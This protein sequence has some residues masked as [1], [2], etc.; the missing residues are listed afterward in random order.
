MKIRRNLLILTLIFTWPIFMM[1]QDFSYQGINYSVLS[2]T[3]LTCQTKPGSSTTSGTTTTTIAGN[4]D[5]AGAVIIPEKVVDASGKEY[6]VTKIGYQSFTKNKN[7]TSVSLPNTILS[8]GESAFEYCSA[9]IG[10]IKLPKSLTEIGPSAFAE[11]TGITGTIHIPAGVTSVP[12]SAFKRCSGITEVILSKSVSSVG[13]FAF[14][15]DSKLS[16]IISLAVTPPTITAQTFYSIASGTKVYVP[17]AGSAGYKSATGWKSLSINNMIDCESVTLSSTSLS[18]NDKE[19]KTLIATITPENVTLPLIEWISSDNTV[20]TVDDEGA[21]TAVGNGEAMITATCGSASAECKVTVGP[22]TTTTVNGINYEIIEGTNTAQVIGCTP[23]TTDIAIESTV[24]IGGQEY[25]VV[26]IKVAAFYSN[27]TITSVSKIPETIAE[28]PSGCFN[29]CSN[30]QEITIPANITSI[31]NRAFA[32]CHKITNIVIPKTVTNIGSGAFQNM[33]GV[34][35]LDVQCNATVDKD[36][37]DG[38]TSLVTL[39][40]NSATL[41][42]RWTACKWTL[43]SVEFGPDVT[44]ISSSAFKGFTKLKSVKFNGSKAV[45][46]NEAFSTC[47]ALTDL[48]LGNSITKI[49]GSA[50]SGCTELNKIIFPESMNFIA[51][52]A[53]MSTGITSIDIPNSITQIETAAFASCPS[54]ITAVIGDGLKSIPMGMF[55]GC[56]KLESVEIG[57]SVATIQSHAFNKCTSLNTLNIPNSVTT[58]QQQAFS[59]CDKLESVTIGNGVMEISDGAFASCTELTYLT[60]GDCQPTIG[61]AWPNSTNLQTIV[62]SSS[63]P[64]VTDAK[65]FPDDVYANAKLYVPENSEQNFKDNE[66]WG[67]FFTNDR[68]NL[69]NGEINHHSIKISPDETVLLEA[70]FT[71]LPENAGNNVTWTSSNPEIATVTQG[72]MVTGIAVGKTVITATSSVNFP[73]RCELTVIAEPETVTLNTTELTIHLGAND[74]LTAAVSPEDADDKTISWSSADEEVAVVDEDGMVTA[75]AVGE[76]IVTATASNGVKAECKVTVIPVVATGLEMSVSEMDLFIGES[77][78]LNAIIEPENTTDKT[79]SWASSNDDIATVENGLVTGVAEGEATITATSHNGLTAT[80][81]VTVKP[82][83]AE[84]VTLDH[85]TFDLTEGDTETLTATVLPE[86][87]TDPT[88]TWSSSDDDIATVE[89]GLVT[90]V[91]EGEATITAACGDVKAECVV[92]VTK[93]VIPAEGITLSSESEELTV[94]DSV[95]LTATITP[96]DVTDPTVIWSS[97]DYDI[98]T[99]ETGLVTAV[100]EGEATIIAACGDVKAECV[101]TVS[102]YTTGLTFVYGENNAVTVTNGEIMT[103]G[104]A[105]IYT[106]E[107]KLAARTDGGRIKG[108]ARGIYIV[109]TRG[110]SIKIS[111]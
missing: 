72:G 103:D 39:K 62:Y 6:R 87:T 76:T 34:T 63:A 78:E 8:I 3:D 90:A 9:I 66:V 71:G 84:E 5:A 13:N 51:T 38:L 35:S 82:I 44:M 50:F 46:D 67:Q 29:Q 69:M 109:V 56:S 53:F 40:Y 88:V 1:A 15:Q 81:T 47:E 23:E 41:P 98:A 102:A 17:E 70:T 12:A 24:S 83:V 16:K 92:T 75:V 80:C 95:E 33:N 32:F 43:E 68:S 26:S 104:A 57:S 37:F 21:V 110:K 54:L 101:V 42:A 25:S 111:L 77:Y 28:I 59:G 100:A 48:D 91:A 49:G 31:G 10:E 94:G 2:T 106:A 97:S 58:I 30:L 105:E 18:M 65:C 19:T 7:I 96:D 79:I 27:T 36:A 55:A 64:G 52:Q 14:A 85:I 20:A 107:G 4:S 93:K 86:G 45:I 74:K 99:V 108:L 60:I 11:C 61:Q 73:V 89:N 22:E